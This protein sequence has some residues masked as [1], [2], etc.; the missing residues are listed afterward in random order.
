MKDY[1]K[2]HEVLILSREYTFTDVKE[3]V[4]APH[5]KKVQTV[6]YYYDFRTGRDRREVIPIELTRGFIL[7]LA[8]QINDIEKEEYDKPYNADLPF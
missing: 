1:N 8:N 5:K 4:V 3:G 2:E 7:D 6:K